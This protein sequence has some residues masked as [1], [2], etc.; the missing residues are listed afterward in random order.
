MGGIGQSSR[1]SSYKDLTYRL[2]LGLSGRHW[3]VMLVIDHQEHG[4]T[5]EQPGRAKQLK[6][7]RP[8][9]IPYAFDN[10]T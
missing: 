8:M 6:Q 1:L 7:G 3:T 5:N 9:T 2:I 10:V 4:S